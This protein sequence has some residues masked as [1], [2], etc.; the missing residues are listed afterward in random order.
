MR[1]KTLKKI[2]EQ[3]GASSKLF[4][5]DLLVKRKRK[6]RSTPRLKSK[7]GQVVVSQEEVVEELAKH[8]EELGS[9]KKSE[10]TMEDRV[11]GSE[12]WS[13]I[14]EMVTFDEVVGIL[15]QLKRVKATGSDGIHEMMMYG[16][17]RMVVTMV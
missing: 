1:R 12:I 7:M 15:K 10:S 3:G 17:T 11:Q 14:C 16:G 6:R 8:W 9:R 2:R 5:S 13:N 4:W